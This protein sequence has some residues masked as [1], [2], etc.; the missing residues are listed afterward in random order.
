MNCKI[1]AV[2]AVDTKLNFFRLTNYQLRLKKTL[3]MS[4][5]L[6]PL[7]PEWRLWVELL[8]GK[9]ANVEVD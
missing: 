4:L 6:R 2:I 5:K 8:Q 7:W 3:E 9:F 1:V